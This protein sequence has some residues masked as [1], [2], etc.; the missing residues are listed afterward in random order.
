M[1]YSTA[2]PKVL[3]DGVRQS[4]T[5]HRTSDPVPIICPFE[6]ALLRMDLCDLTMFILTSASLG[7]I[8]AAKEGRAN[9][10]PACLRYI[11][12]HGRKYGLK[13]DHLQRQQRR[14]VAHQKRIEEGSR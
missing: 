1:T 7:S 2:N 4:N 8:R 9:I 12:R 11:Q 13:A 6:A 3:Q 14:F 5:S 10:P